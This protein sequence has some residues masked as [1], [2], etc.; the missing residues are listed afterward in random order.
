M[1]YLILS[2]FKRAVQ[3]DNLQQVIN[4]DASILN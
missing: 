1:A 3:A 2:D 4:K